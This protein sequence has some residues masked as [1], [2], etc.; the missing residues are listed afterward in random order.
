MKHRLTGILTGISLLSVPVARSQAIPPA[1]EAPAASP[2]RM[3]SASKT[4]VST[5][6]A[7]GSRGNTRCDASGNV[8]FEASTSVTDTGPLLKISHDGAS[9]FVYPFPPET[10]SQAEIRWN[11]TP[12]GKLFL[13][14][15]DFK[16]YKLMRI[17]SDGRAG[18][19]I[20]L[21]IPEG[22]SIERFAIADSGVVYARGYGSA[23]IADRSHSL[24]T[25]RKSYAAIFA[26]SGKLIRELGQD[27]NPNEQQINLKSLAGQPLEEDVIA[28][29]DGRFYLLERNDVLV[30]NQSG[31]K[32][33]ELKFK[34]PDPG[35]YAVR[36]IYS[37]GLVSITLHSIHRGPGHRT[38][39]QVRCLL[40]NA[41]TGEEMGDFTFDPAAT[42]NVLCFDSEE[43]YSLYAIDHDMAVW[44]IFPIR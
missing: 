35:A 24:D 12:E 15:G 4:V 40:L 39:V 25:P 44:Q 17:T 31:E 5:V 22:T 6:P 13:L 14:F 3:L 36:V 27:L 34:K 26:D 37:N 28:G 32:E 30:F 1:A 18:R 38:D 2:P 8:Y 43:G 9:H 41:Q 11:V 20:S 42:N 16:T 29:T 21:D 19:T 10:D 23:N 33:R 7:F